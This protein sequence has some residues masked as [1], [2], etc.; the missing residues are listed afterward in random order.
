MNPETIKTVIVAVIAVLL[1]AAGW[2]TEGW[3]K[4]AEIDRIE[5]AHADQRARD[6]Q[7]AAEEIADAT[8]RG[9]ELA[10]RAA[11]AEATRD[12]ALEETRNALRKFT[13]GKPCLSGAAVRLLNDAAG[14]KAADLPA[15]PG[16]PAGADAAFATDTDIALWAAHARRS[17]D[18][19]RGRVDALR[20]FFEEA[21]SD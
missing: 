8:K 7:A 16:Q 19:C 14:F 21:P 12:T 3:R 5:R 4:D 2:V 9:N 15:T 13:T 1:F 20:E 18:T 17:F 6:A 10:A 11:A